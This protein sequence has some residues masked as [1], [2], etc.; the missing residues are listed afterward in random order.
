MY[1]GVLSLGAVEP[2]CI[3]LAED[4]ECLFINKGA[5]VVYNDLPRSIPALNPLLIS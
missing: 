3:R 2:A 4:M 1:Y 5:L